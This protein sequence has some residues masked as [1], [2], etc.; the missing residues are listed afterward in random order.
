[1]PDRTTN[2][3]NH[4]TLAER[5]AD[6]SDRRIFIYSLLFA[7]TFFI[8]LVLNSPSLLAFAVTLMMSCGA[9]FLV[10][11]LMRWRRDQERLDREKYGRRGRNS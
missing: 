3:S 5:W 9:F 10:L 4:R 1:M 11:R 6:T 2:E 7:G 8:P